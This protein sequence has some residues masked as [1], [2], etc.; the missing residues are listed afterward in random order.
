[1]ILSFHCFSESYQIVSSKRKF[2]EF[3]FVNL[4]I[5]SILQLFIYIWFS[6]LATRL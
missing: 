4:H 2:F 6:K 1:M 5:R 3:L